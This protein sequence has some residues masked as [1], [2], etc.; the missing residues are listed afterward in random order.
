MNFAAVFATSLWSGYALPACHPENGASAKG[1]RSGRTQDRPAP[2]Q[3]QGIP[4]PD[5]R[6][7]GPPRPFDLAAAWR[8]QRC[9]SAG[10]AAADGI[11]AGAARLLLGGRRRGRRFAGGASG[12]PA[13]TD[14]L[15]EFGALLG[16]FRRDHRI[17]RRQAPFGAVF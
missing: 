9:R 14:P 1:I 6:R 11:S 10:P 2:I 12:P 15:S 8:K 5:R 13:Q 3:P 4:A 7:P 16:I 17:I